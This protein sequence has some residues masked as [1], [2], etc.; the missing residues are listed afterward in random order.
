MW[1]SWMAERGFYQLIQPAG[2]AE[3]EQL[4][5]ALTVIIWNALYEGTR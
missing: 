1:A 5:S 4:L 3:A 2:D